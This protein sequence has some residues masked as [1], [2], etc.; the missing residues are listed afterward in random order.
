MSHSCISPIFSCVLDTHQRKPKGKS[1]M[2]KSETLI[3]LNTHDTGRRQQN[4][5]KTTKHPTQKI[6]KDQPHGPNTN[7]V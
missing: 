5:K 7:G 3:T 6:K 1:R 2:D 4:R